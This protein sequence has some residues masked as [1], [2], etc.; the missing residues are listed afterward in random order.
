MLMSELV[1]F[2]PL[3]GAEAVFNKATIKQIA[4]LAVGVAVGMILVPTL[5]NLVA[6][7]RTTTGV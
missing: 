4:V 1:T 3:S 2:H 6:K 7:I 5:N